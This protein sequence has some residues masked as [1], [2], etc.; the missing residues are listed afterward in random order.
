[1]AAN[2]QRQAVPLI[3]PDSPFVGTGVEAKVAHDSGASLTT[4]VD[5]T[6]VYADSRRVDVE[7][8]DGIHSYP[9]RKFESSN[10]GT[11]MNQT[12]VVK[13]K[14]KAGNIAEQTINI[15]K[16]LKLSAI[17][18]TNPPKRI[19]YVEGQS[20]DTT[21]MKVV[22]KYNNGREEEITKYENHLSRCLP[23][24]S[25]TG[26]KVLLR[27]GRGRRERVFRGHGRHGHLRFG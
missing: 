27:H 20:F 1:M 3:K 16:I 10:Q 11:C 23:W 26:Q 17:E 18:I 25:R 5:G 21:G 9:L 2:M 8:K 19:N 24:H 7:A 14:D 6:V 22:A 4:K 15:T 13:V 12:V